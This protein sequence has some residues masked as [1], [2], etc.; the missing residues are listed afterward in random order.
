MKHLT[1]N[2]SWNPALVRHGGGICSC[3][4]KL[5]REQLEIPALQQ[6]WEPIW[7]GYGP[8]SPRGFL[9]SQSWDGFG[10]LCRH[11]P[12][13]KACT[14]PGTRHPAWLKAPHFSE[15]SERSH[16][17]HCRV[18]TCQ[19]RALLKLEVF[20]TWSTIREIFRSINTWILLLCSKSGWD[21]DKTALWSW[22]QAQNRN[23]DAQPGLH[24]STSSLTLFT[25]ASTT[26][27]LHCL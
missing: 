23:P 12:S 16:S 11:Q 5:L 17:D 14:E 15:D 26:L 10:M 3:R 24:H 19:S 9:Q 27:S 4:A 1:E 8:Q 21:E 25:K 13:C 6:P 20:P 7:R 22:E 18:I 2:T